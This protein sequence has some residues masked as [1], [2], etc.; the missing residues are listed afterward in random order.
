MVCR[1]YITPGGEVKILE[2]YRKYLTHFVYKLNNLWEV[3][4]L[5]SETVGFEG[6]LNSF[7]PFPIYFFHVKIHYYKFHSEIWDYLG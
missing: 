5:R 7:S 2:S 1:H 6:D 4:G 3:S